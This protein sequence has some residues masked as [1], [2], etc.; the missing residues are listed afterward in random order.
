MP[1]IWRRHK[2]QG[3]SQGSRFKTQARLKEQ[4]TRHKPRFKIQASRKGTSFKP[5]D[6]CKLKT[7][8]L[9]SFLILVP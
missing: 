7:E 3:T 4:G 8:V 6:Y 5:Q 9:G 2:A 1:N